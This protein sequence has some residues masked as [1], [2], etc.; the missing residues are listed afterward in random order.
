MSFRLSRE[1]RCDVALLL[2]ALAALLIANV[3]FLAWERYS[4]I[5]D[6]AAHLVYG[7]QAY[8][9]IGRLFEMTE[10]PPLPYLPGVVLFHLFGPSRSTAVMSNLVWVWI[11]ILSVYWI[12]RRLF[13]RRVGL[14]AVL[15]TLGF[16]ITLGLSRMYLAENA[17]AALTTASV[18]LLLTTER[19]ERR[20]ASLA[21]GACCGLGLLTKLAFPVFLAPPLLVHLA[22]P[23]AARSFGKR[24]FVNLGLAAL[25]ALAIALLWYTPESFHVR[26]T[27]L[28]STEENPLFFTVEGYWR[29]LL[30][31]VYSMVD[32]SMSYLGYGVLAVVAY[33]AASRR[34][35]AL[36]E[37]VA[38]FV[39]PL[40]L[41]SIFP[42]RAARY[43]YPGF[44]AA[45]L[46]VAY[47]ICAVIRGRRTRRLLVGGLL[48]WALVV[49]GILTVPV[50]GRGGHHR[51]LVETRMHAAL[52]RR[53]GLSFL[54]Y[55]EDFWIRPPRS[56]TFGFDRIVAIM[57]SYNKKAGPPVRGCIQLLN[58]SRA[59]SGGTGVIHPFSWPLHTHLAIS[60]RRYL[61]DALL[62]WQGALYRWRPG[63]DH[64][65]EAKRLVRPTFITAHRFEAR[66]ELERRLG[67]VCLGS[68]SS[69]ITP[70]HRDA[71]NVYLFDP[72]TRAH[73]PCAR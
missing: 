72:A 64:R 24:Q 17:W 43:L 53:V 71:V 22:R 3:L 14:V 39:V 9:D 58:I 8:H 16:P 35:S 50:S 65:G 13:D 41:F 25:A 49:F 18:A 60:R 40:L 5:G 47:W 54:N 29:G 21:F 66:S 1:Q 57:D 56:E 68:V 26:S 19:F 55:R 11:T 12:G 67:L 42:K 23:L 6:E 61:H 52:A 38:W 32:F 28:Y 33:L 59:A 10:W 30:L 34:R 70:R 51:L 31:Y 37:L 46:M 36:L 63:G 48:V 62:F 45:A 7:V 2:S 27:S 4:F 44:P 73:R 20:G 69:D 15:V